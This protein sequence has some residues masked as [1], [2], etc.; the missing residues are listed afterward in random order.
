MV[1]PPLWA[2]GNSLVFWSACQFSSQNS[3]DKDAINSGSLC[4]LVILSTPSLPNQHILPLLQI[5][6]FSK[7]C[8]CLGEKGR[9]G[10]DA[11]AP[12]FH[13]L[14]DMRQPSPVLQ[15]NS[16]RGGLTRARRKMLR[17][18]RGAKQFISWLHL[19]KSI[20]WGTRVVKQIMTAFRTM[21]LWH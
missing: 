4:I 12:G 11:I 19:S 10:K 15:K 3:Q 13:L 21:I 17:P 9:V 6:A 2:E 1:Q 14:Y 7:M 8:V 5:N 20:G 16:P 18:M